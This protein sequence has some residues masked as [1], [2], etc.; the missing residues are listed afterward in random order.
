MLHMTQNRTLDIN[1]YK[2]FPKICDG[3]DIICCIIK[4]SIVS[5]FLYEG[6]KKKNKHFYG[7]S[8]ILYC[9]KIKRAAD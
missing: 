4:L 9:L 3:E 8:F 7:I 5:T 6:I 1:S 2:T